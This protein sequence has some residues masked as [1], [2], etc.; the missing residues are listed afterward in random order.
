[1]GDQN[2]RL[3]GD[4]CHG[5]SKTRMGFERSETWQDEALSVAMCVSTK[6]FFGQSGYGTRWI[7]RFGI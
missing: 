7:G 1:M 4:F 5:E 3:S 6:A 2:N